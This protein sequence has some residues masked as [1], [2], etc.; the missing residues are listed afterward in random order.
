MIVINTQCRILYI[1]SGIGGSELLNVKSS[2]I[3]QN[4]CV[5][6]VDEEEEEE[7]EDNSS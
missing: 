3:A 6:K 7:E 1:G 4:K 5:K 2:Q